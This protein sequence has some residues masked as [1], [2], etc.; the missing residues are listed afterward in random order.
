MCLA[1][2][3]VHPNEML[4]DIIPVWHLGNHLCLS[5]LICKTGIIILV[6]HL[7][8]SAPGCCKGPKGEYSQAGRAWM[9]EEPHKWSIVVLVNDLALFVCL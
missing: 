2:R 9:G 5:F 6:A 4:V 7:P 3:L 1:Q 8:P